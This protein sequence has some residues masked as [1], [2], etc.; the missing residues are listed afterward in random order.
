MECVSC[1]RIFEE[2]GDAFNS[3]L[4]TE[5]KLEKVARAIVKYL[6]IKACHFRVLSR[7]QR[8]LDHVASFGLSRKFLDKGPVD[9][10]KSVSEALRGHVV[11]VEDCAD[12]PRIQFPEEHVEEGIVSLLTAPLSARGNVIG[13]MRL[14]SGKR[15]E[16][17]EQELTAIKTLASFSTSAITHSMF[18]DILGEV[19]TAARS[20][21]DLKEVLESTVRVVCESLRVRGST[22][23][24]LDR[25][26]NLELRATFGLSQQYLE[27]AS[28]DPGEAVAEALNGT[29]VA[30]LDAH[31]DP[32]IRHHDEMERE[33]ISSVLFVPLMSREK[34]IGVLSV[35]THNPYTFSD[36]EKE[37]MTALGEQ[38]ALSIRNAQMY[39]TIKRRYQDVV[40]EFQVWFE[41]YQTYPV[42]K[43]DHI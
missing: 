7:D 37:L 36:D 24:L 11:M 1:V 3:T 35:Y 41:H 42:R 5:E 19:A 27:T 9:A 29:C 22:I 13:V 10:E 26:G 21:L 40:D 15:K 6:D 43:N 30:I 4:G 17:S 28:T 25:R 20:S 23:R 12:D 33:K 34:V 8:S 31:T 14:S 2:V 39:H 32:R 18:H 16:F 38:C